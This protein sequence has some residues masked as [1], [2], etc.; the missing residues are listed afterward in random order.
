MAFPS[1]ARGAAFGLLLGLIGL[2]GAAR[3][4]IIGSPIALN[5]VNNL[6]PTMTIGDL[7]F[8]FAGCSGTECGRSDIQIVGVPASA[9]TGPGGGIQLVSISSTPLLGTGG[10]IGL[11]WYVDTLPLATGGSNITGVSGSET[12]TANGGTASGGTSVHNALNRDRTSY[13]STSLG[14]V[15]TNIDGSNSAVTLALTSY[16]LGFNSDWT[17]S[18][19]ATVNTITQ[20]VSEVPEPASITLML[21]GAVML[22]GVRRRLAA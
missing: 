16:G 3:A 13:T 19:G 15:S 11:E 6:T 17:A 18:G 14:T 5:T 1:L 10:D 7:L 20:F 8:T 12:G 21:A 9:S 22:A 4:D 2:S